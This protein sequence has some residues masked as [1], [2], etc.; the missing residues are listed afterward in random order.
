M[1]GQ[2]LLNS[3]DLGPISIFNLNT[4]YAKSAQNQ[5]E[6]RLQSRDS[7]TRTLYENEKNYLL[8]DYIVKVL[9]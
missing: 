3:L 4:S 2:Q 8:V 9:S 7:F 5:K 6:S 1:Y